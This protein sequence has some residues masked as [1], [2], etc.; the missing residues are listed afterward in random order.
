MV[1]HGWEIRDLR[2]RPV[3]LGLS[4]LIVEA[5]QCILIGDVDGAVDEREAIGC[6][7]VLGEDALHFVGAVAIAV[8][9]QRQPIAAFHGTLAEALDEARDQVL[10]AQGRRVAARPLRNQD[11]PIG[12][13]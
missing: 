11:V 6:V 13:D 1:D 2:R 3:R 9:Q 10:R 4:V 7:E 12:K 5:H 8:T